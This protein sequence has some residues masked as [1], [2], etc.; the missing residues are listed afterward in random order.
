MNIVVEGPDGSGKTYLAKILAETFHMK[1][2]KSKG[3]EHYPGEM[4]ERVKAYLWLDNV[5]FDRHPCISQNIYRELS[6]GPE[7]PQELIEKFYQTKPILISCLPVC[8]NLENHDASSECDTPEYLKALRENLPTIFERYDRW[9]A[10]N[11]VIYYSMGQDI[12]RFIENLRR[13]L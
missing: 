8:S 13:K 6:N 3:P 2:E 12:P 1:Y 9:S 5:V 11:D 4:V 7:L 10:S